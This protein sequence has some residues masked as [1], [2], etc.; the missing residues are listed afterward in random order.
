MREVMVSVGDQAQGGKHKPAGFDCMCAQCLKPSLLAILASP[1]DSPAVR[2]ENAPKKGHAA[3]PG[4]VG[5]RA[6]FWQKTKAKPHQSLGFFNVLS[7]AC[8]LLIFPMTEN[9]S[10]IGS[11]SLRATT[12]H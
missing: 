3:D 4:K 5:R 11:R 12:E 10:Q 8:F 6:F 1:L 2:R 9:L 7:A